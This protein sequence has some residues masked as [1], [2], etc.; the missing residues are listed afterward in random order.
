MALL[1]DLTRATDPRLRA[2]ARDLAAALVIPAARRAGPS[3]PGGSARLGPVRDGGVDLD[4]DATVERLGEHPELRAEDL[5]WRGWRRPGRAV[6]LVVDASGSVTG[7]PLAT[8]VI[9]AAALAARTGPGDQL[10]V[11]AFWSKAVVLR[12]IRDVGPV[13]TAVDRVLALRGGDTTDLEG[14]LRAALAQMAEASVARRDV[15]LLSDGMANEGGDPLPI[16]AAAAAMGVPLHVLALAPEAESLDACRALA[17]AG[18]GRMAEL[19]RPS[20]AADAV[21]DILG[22]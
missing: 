20:A 12:H 22:R 7:P 9:T 15:V 4:I 17:G 10:A 11:V 21:V 5:R 2:Q 13:S 3:R 1:A 16:A 14:G 6:V 18:G 8:A 19:G